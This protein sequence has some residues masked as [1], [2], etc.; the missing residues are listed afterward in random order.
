M[1]L[2]KYKSRRKSS[3]N[4]AFGSSCRALNL[5]SQ[6]CKMEIN[7]RQVSGSVAVETLSRIDERMRNSGSLCRS[8]AFRLPAAA[9]RTYGIVAHRTVQQ[10]CARATGRYHKCGNRLKKHYG[11]ATAKRAPGA[12]VTQPVHQKEHGRRSVLY[13]RFVTRLQQHLPNPRSLLVEINIF[14]LVT[15]L[16]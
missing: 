12:R 13:T 4:W 10:P 9:R 11:M 1:L 3:S 7:S 15:L 14:A 8:K 6:G 16:S 2:S 5:R